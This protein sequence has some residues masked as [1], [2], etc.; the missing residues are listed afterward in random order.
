MLEI[1]AI[2]EEKSVWENG[3]L[4]VWKNKLFNIDPHRLA[5]DMILNAL[6]KEGPPAYDSLTPDPLANIESFNSKEQDALVKLLSMFE[7]DNTLADADT[8]ARIK[9]QLRHRPSDSA[10]VP[11]MDGHEGEAELEGCCTWDVD[12]D[13]DIHINALQL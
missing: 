2:S 3:L 4:D 1:I 11:D 6:F 10:V 7:I 12:S 8:I 9:N 13:D 5:E